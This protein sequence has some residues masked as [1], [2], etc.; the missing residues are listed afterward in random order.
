MAT[1]TKMFRWPTRRHTPGVPE[2]TVITWILLSF[3]EPHISSSWRPG[4]RLGR[5]SRAPWSLSWRAWEVEYGR[6]VLHRLRGGARLEVDGR[7]FGR[8][9]AGSVGW[10]LGLAQRF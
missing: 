5:G 2:S 10:S 3:L 9:K 7:A 8:F 1:P 6:W 4:R